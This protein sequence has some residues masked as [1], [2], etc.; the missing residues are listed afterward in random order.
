[1]TH[2][3]QISQMIQQAREVAEDAVRQ[4]AL[5]RQHAP[6]VRIGNRLEAIEGALRYLA[7]A[8]DDLEPKEPAR[9]SDE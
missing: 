8:L 3:E 5:G 7:N 4:G 1:M 2:A 6:E 9:P